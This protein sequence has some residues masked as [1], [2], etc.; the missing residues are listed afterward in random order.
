MKKFKSY[1]HFLKDYKIINT[2]Q[3]ELVLNILDKTKE[4]LTAEEI[5]LQAKDLDDTISLSTIYR[6]LSLFDKKKI[7][8]KMSGIDENSAKYKLNRADHTH[9]LICLIYLL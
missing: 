7:T 8:I 3:R 4:N 6:T 1:H 9:F 5:F 2:K